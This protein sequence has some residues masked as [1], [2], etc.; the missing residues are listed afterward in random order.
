[1]SPLFD[2][3]SQVSGQWR[4]V[5]LETGKERKLHSLSSPAK[6]KREVEGRP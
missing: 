4:M 3:K 2:T 1:M 5:Q 6:T